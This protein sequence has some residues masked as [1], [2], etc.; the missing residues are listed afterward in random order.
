MLPFA[1]SLN[2]RLSLDPSMGKREAMAFST[3]QIQRDP[4]FPSAREPRTA[5]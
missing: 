2:Y 5:F 4:T 1:V 3:T